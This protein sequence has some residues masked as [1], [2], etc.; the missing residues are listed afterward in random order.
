MMERYWSKKKEVF[1][2][3]LE[4]NFKSSAKRSVLS[5]ERLKQKSF[6]HGIYPG[7]TRHVWWTDGETPS[8]RTS[9][10]KTKDFPIGIVTS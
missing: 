8:V 6:V 9:S 5:C 4:K 7:Y 1:F 10:G 3:W 2:Y